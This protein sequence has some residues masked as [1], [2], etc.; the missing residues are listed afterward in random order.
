M[1]VSDLKQA[2]EQ[3]EQQRVQ[4][5]YQEAMPLYEQVL[6][7]EPT[8]LRARLGV[9]HCLLNTGE[10]EL[11]LQH[12]RQAAVDHPN[13]VEARLL[14][15]KMLLMLDRTDEGKAELQKVLELD[16]DNAEGKRYL[17]YL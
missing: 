10:F 12:F 9:A 1:A 2:L 6:Q 16:P 4:G 15:A 14:H 13:S 3:A 8:N 17:A 5:R 7:G 11:G